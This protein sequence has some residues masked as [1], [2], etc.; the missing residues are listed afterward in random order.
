MSVL[1]GVWIQQL[2][3]LMNAEQLG[4][5]TTH[6]YTQPGRGRTTRFPLQDKMMAASSKIQLGGHSRTL[7]GT[8]MYDLGN[9]GLLLR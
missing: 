3:I 8:L 7:S 2:S 6:K 4:L 1:E 5:E 9:S